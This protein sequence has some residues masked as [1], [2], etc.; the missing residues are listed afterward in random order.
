MNPRLWWAAWSPMGLV[1]Y[2]II[3]RGRFFESLYKGS[4]LGNGLSL[5]SVRFFGIREYLL[6]PWGWLVFPALAI[7]PYSLWLTVRNVRHIRRWT[8][9]IFLGWV[10]LLCGTQYALLE[11][12]RICPM[13]GIGTKIRGPMWNDFGGFWHVLLLSWK[14]H[15]SNPIQWEREF[16]NVYR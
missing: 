7:L 3:N 10:F 12:L 14:P 1:V 11:T 5:W 8:G 9:V 16:P 4:G 6:S 13:R 15:F 2:L